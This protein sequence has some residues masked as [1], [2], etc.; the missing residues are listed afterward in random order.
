VAGALAAAQ[1]E[2]ERVE[3]Q[4]EELERLTSAVGEVA[5]LPFLAVDALRTADVASLARWLTPQ[6]QESRAG[7]LARDGQG[8]AR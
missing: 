7:A 8:A 1:F 2:H 3:D 6:G 4:R 5:T